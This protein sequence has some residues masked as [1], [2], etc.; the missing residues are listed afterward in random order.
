LDKKRKTRLP[1]AASDRSNSAPNCLS[2]RLRLSLKLAGTLDRSGGYSDRICREHIIQQFRASAQDRV[3]EANG[4]LTTFNSNLRAQTD[5]G[6]GS[7][8]PP[9]RAGKSTFLQRFFVVGGYKY[10][11]QHINN[12]R[13]A[14][15]YYT[16]SATSPSFESHS[17]AAFDWFEFERLNTLHIWELW[18]LV[19]FIQV[20]ILTPFSI[21]FDCK[22]RQETPFF[23][24]RSLRDL[25]SL[26]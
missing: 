23:V 13:L 8:A 19:I 10:P 14:P 26:R 25:V 21:L 11:N 17:R 22:A 3:T 15:I 6:R 18:V 5:K 2:R 4:Q 16:L 20:F 7:G 1:A 24:W 12:T 9:D